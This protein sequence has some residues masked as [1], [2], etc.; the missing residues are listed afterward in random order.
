[1]RFEMWTI[2]A[3]V[4]LPI[5]LHDQGLLP[6]PVQGLDLLLV[7]VQDLDH[8][9]PKHNPLLMVTLDEANN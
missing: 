1:M 2:P 5:P 6:V 9:F 4:L 8:L 7:T 3:I